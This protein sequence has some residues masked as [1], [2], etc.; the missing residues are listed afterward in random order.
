MKVNYKIF[1][2]PFKH[3]FTISKA[4]KTVQPTLLVELDYFGF[5]GYGE[6]P[7]ITYYN[8]TVDQMI[9]DLEAESV[10]A[11]KA[12]ESRYEAKAHREGRTPHYFT[13]HRIPRT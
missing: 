1:E 5:K 2:L 4:S 13:F 12:I 9:A 3:P 6:A 11:K 10:A 8:I 7:A